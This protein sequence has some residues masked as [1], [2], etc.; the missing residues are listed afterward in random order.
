MDDLQIEQL[1]LL[2]LRR[3]ISMIAIR[4][5]QAGSKTGPANAPRLFFVPVDGSPASGLSVDLAIRL[6]R[7]A[8][9]EIVLIDVL[10]S[11]LEAGLICPADAEPALFGEP[12]PIAP[13]L[14]DEE[15]TAR[16]LRQVLLPLRGRVSQAG[17]EVSARLLH[18]DQPAGE[19]R[20]LV[21]AAGPDRALVLSN[22][23]NL[24]PPLRQLTGD[25][26]LEPPCT[27]Y[28]T[29]TADSRAHSRTAVVLSL[30]RWVWQRLTR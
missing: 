19:V 27:V 21:N 17:I 3:P 13:L 22:P 16:R 7:L 29:G 20:A 24:L 28:L 23:L 26:L 1:S 30:M 14:D 2:P 11:G 9:S 25:L 12:G 10:G 15:R 8:Q 4:S 6:A 5:S 18:S